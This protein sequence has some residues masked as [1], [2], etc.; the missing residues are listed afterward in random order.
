MHKEEHKINRV[1]GLL[2]DQVSELDARIINA[3]ATKKLWDDVQKNKR[4]KVTK[5]F[6]ERINSQ[7]NAS[8]NIFEI[9][10][11]MNYDQIQEYI[12]SNPRSV[13]TFTKAKVLREM[14]RHINHL[15]EYGVVLSQGI[16][17][18]NSLNAIRNSY[19]H[20]IADELTKTHDTA[21]CKLIREESRRQVDSIKKVSE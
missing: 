18:E 12:I 7:K 5:E 8:I 3:I 19:G 20:Q 16:N 21:K 2:M 4:E 10:E 13:N 1:R 17:G 6:K 15:K 14:L 11:N 9:T